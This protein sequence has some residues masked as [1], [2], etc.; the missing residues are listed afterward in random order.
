M[1]GVEPG[2]LVLFRSKWRLERG[3]KKRRG[4]EEEEE[5]GEGEGGSREREEENKRENIKS[6]LTTGGRKRTDEGG[7]K[8]TNGR[9]KGRPRP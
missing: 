1:N 6:N 8:E 3:K 7:S 2:W 5:E 4:L 9:N